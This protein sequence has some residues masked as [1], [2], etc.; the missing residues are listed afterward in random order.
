M[1]QGEI[2]I[3]EL[4]Q[5]ANYVGLTQSTNV[6]KHFIDEEIVHIHCWE[7][8]NNEDRYVLLY[9]D[10]DQL[11]VNFSNGEIEG[12]DPLEGDELLGSWTNVEQWNEYF[13]NTEEECSE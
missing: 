13:G 4:T 2:L 1:N 10:I 11:W 12:S 7:D 5:F 6:Y 3:A 9:E 8:P